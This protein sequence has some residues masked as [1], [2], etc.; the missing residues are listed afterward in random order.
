M[1]YFALIQALC[2]TAMSQP[3][4][5][6]RHQVER[7]RNALQKDG[8]VKEA[9][10]ISSILAAA[11]RTKDLVP[12]RITWSQASLIGEPLTK[13]V[14]LPVDRE[15]S[16]PLVQCIFPENLPNT[17]PL[18]DASVQ[19]ATHSILG[20]WG[21]FEQLEV[22]G[23]HPA[24]T[25]LIYGPPG[26]GKTQLGLW[27][28]GQLGLPVVLARLD[29]LISSFLGTTSKNIG[30]LFNF[31]ARYRCLLLL[32]EFDAIA[33]LRDDPQEVGEIK[34]VVNTL[35][36]NLDARRDL[37]LTIG[38]TNHQALLDPAVWR[39]FEV[40][41]EIPRPSFNARIEIV[42]RYLP[43]LELPDGYVRVLAWLMDGATGSE[44]EALIRLIKK[45]RVMRLEPERF[46]D[47]LRRFVTLNSARVHVGRKEILMKDPPDLADVLL[48][49]QEL[50]L[51]QSDIAAVLGVSKP[52]MSRWCKSQA[53]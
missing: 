37:G 23:V 20:E 5:A 10:A 42:K 11:E 33:K 38:I 49:D 2:R 31:A 27:M 32:D 6:I 13:T 48:R 43:P 28:A 34:R 8:Q 16:A 9:E 4:D 29:G 40:Q 18:F 21:N 35:L 3:T 36:Q 24:R 14:P 15:T 12:S 25:C 22:A 51:G 7:L 44:I 30:T 39:R 45:E 17:S 46:I 19:E 50:G 53:V 26:T 52:T 47:T 1:E 41:L